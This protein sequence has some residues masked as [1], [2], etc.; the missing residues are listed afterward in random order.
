MMEQEQNGASQDMKRWTAKRKT[1]LVLGLIRESITAAQTARTYYL[2][3]FK[4]VGMA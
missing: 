4:I 3:P 2:T 1:A